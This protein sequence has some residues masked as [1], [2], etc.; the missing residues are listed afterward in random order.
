MGTIVDKE[1]FRGLGRNKMGKI[2][3]LAKICDL[4][5]RY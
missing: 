3:D 5:N 4:A 1:G 2:D